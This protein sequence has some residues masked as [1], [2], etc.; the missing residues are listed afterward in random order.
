[1]TSINSISVPTSIPE[2]NPGWFKA[3]LRALLR[4]P[5]GTAGDR[6]SDM[7]ARR[8]GEIELEQLR[9]GLGTLPHAF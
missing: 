4:F 7:S 3:V 9:S 2:Q 6:G 1:M 5:A 8:C